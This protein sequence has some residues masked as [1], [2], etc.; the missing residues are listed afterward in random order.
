MHPEPSMLTESVVVVDAAETPVVV[1]LT[2]DDP[3]Q[4]VR[5]VFTVYVYPVASGTWIVTWEL[6]FVFPE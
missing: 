2:F 5:I 6:A 3:E 4:A 1:L